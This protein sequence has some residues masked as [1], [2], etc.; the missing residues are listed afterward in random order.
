M[1]RMMTMIMATIANATVVGVAPCWPVAL[2]VQRSDHFTAQAFSRFFWRDFKPQKLLLFGGLK[3]Q[4]LS[5][6]ST[7]GYC[8]LTK[9]VF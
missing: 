5:K 9:T 1:L 8:I 4:P 3:I 6:C 2:C 7:H